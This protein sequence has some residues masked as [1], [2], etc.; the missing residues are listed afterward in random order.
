MFPKNT[1]PTAM[2]LIQNIL[3]LPIGV[4]GLYQNEGTAHLPQ[5]T[6]LRTK[7]NEFAELI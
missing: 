2:I 6:A 4:G 5:R 1:I 3:I 7:K